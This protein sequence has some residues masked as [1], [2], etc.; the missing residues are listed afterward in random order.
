MGSI[1]IGI[2]VGV[3]IGTVIEILAVLLFFKQKYGALT[4]SKGE[5]EKLQRELNDVTA[6][7]RAEKDICTRLN[8]ELNIAKSELQN[9]EAEL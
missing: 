9:K 4:I 1:L 2:V 8:S 6:E 7:L 3:V 5:Y